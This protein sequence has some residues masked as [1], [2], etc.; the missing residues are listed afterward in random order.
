MRRKAR[1]AALV[2]ATAA[3]AVAAGCGGGGGAEGG[4]GVKPI[5]KIGPLE[6][7]LNLIAWQGYTEPNVVK[8]FEAQTGCQVHVQYGQT[9]DDM[10]RLMR[11][12]NFDGVSASGD[13]TNRLIAAGD[14]VPVDVQK[15]VPD[16][17]DI[18]S[19]LKSP[20]HN[21]V[22]GLHYGVSYEW[23][24]DV[25]MYNKDVVKPAPD[26]W[27]V[28]F[29]GTSYSGKVDA[30]DSPIYIADAAVYLKATQP[31]LKIT[32]PYELTQD[33]FDA[34]VNLLKTQRQQIGNY[35]GSYTSQIQDFK[36][37]SIVIGPT[38]PYQYNA[39]HADKQ[40]VGVVLPKE[41]A[42]GW[43]DTW[44]LSSQAKDPNCMLK[45]MA[46][47]TTPQV[48]AKTAYTFGSAPANPKA[49]AILDKEVKNYCTDYHVTDPSYFHSIAYWKTPLTSCG[50]SR[51][52][53]CIPYSEWTQ[54]WTEIK[55][56]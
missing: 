51:G 44:M 22:D 36:T 34:A 9:S 28:I 8:P 2:C 19:A 11:T 42:T 49:C 26:S 38:W 18:S 32:D 14:V 47:A 33:Q 23:G 3:L 55:N 16:W 46:Y 43:A 24:A 1:W 50:D 13:A 41:G 12:G 52:D 20:P 39:L 56:S 30:Y 29:N 35:W 48:Q 53:T 45:W 10:V 17:K 37:G 27:G 54:A 6:G 21:T 5:S 15:L 25:L 31:D 4:S 7:H 40:P